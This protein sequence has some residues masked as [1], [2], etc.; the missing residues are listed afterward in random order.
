LKENPSY[1]NLF[2]VDARGM[3]F[4][5]A[6][7]FKPHSIKHRKY[8]QDILKTR[9]FSVGEYVIGLTSKLPSLHFA[10]PISDAK[11]R[12]KGAVAV[13]LNLDRYQQML[14]MSKLPQGSSIALSD[15]KHVGLL[16]YPDTQKYAG[17]PDLPYMVTHMSAE[18]QE[19][20]FTDIGVDGIRRL[21]AYKRFYLKG[22]ASPYLFMRVGIPEKIALS[23]AGKV[24][25]I[26]F[27]L[28]GC[29]FLLS[30]LSA[31]FIG[32]AV[33]VRNMKKLVD[34]TRRFGQG[35]L[36][37]RTLLGYT[38]GELGQL[39]QSF[40]EMADALE[41]R[42]L[43]QKA[44]KQQLMSSL[45]EKE[46]LL[47]E[48]QHRVKN[49][50]LTISGIL[51]LQFEHIK[52]NKSKDAFITSMNRI[53][54]MTKIHTRLYQSESFSVFSF[55]GYI[56]E[57]VRGLSGSYGFP[58]ENIISDIEDISISIDTANSVGLILNELVSNTMKHAFPDGRKGQITISLRE[59]QSGL[60]CLNKEPQRLILTVSDNGIG[61]P[62][63]IDFKNIES[64]GLSL[65][66][67]LVEQING[68]MESIRENG[69]RFIITFSIDQ[70]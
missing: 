68:T 21:Y 16:R 10:Y 55:K 26:S 46:I 49:N 58:P 29:A 39:A 57:L 19:G 64:V 23:H 31:W 45:H 69:T 37:T 6:L 60:N 63:H 56:E 28:F 70:E 9:K 41:Q 22:S 8:F 67:Q 43:E 53:K 4:S 3:V 38:R 5:M 2:A 50:L 65:I 42:D 62:P 27:L 32:K 48:L 47:K 44:V 54:A 59:E 35:D 66:V 20:I 34:T 11:G 12:L 61:L 1:A 40:D 33:I 25:Q 52:D 17:L 14:I 36:K 24:L 30:M 15:H 18:P 51:A 13:S 7:P